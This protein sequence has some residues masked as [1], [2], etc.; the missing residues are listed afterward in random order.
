MCKI[1]NFCFKIVLIHLCEFSPLLAIFPP[2]AITNQE[3]YKISEAIF[4][5]HARYKHYSSEIVRRSLLNFIEELDPLRVYFIQEDIDE[6]LDPSPTFL[7]QVMNDYYHQK[8]SAFYDIYRCFLKAIHRRNEIEK[9]IFLEEI[10][11][12][13]SLAREPLDSNWARDSEGLKIKLLKFNE[14]QRVAAKNLPSD[15]QRDLLWQ[16]IQKRRLLKEKEF[17]DASFEDQKRQVLVYF[18]KAV[19][20]SLDSHTMF[21]T[22]QE[23]RQFFIQVQQKLFGIGAQLRDDLDGFTI[24][25][26]IPGG[27]AQRSGLLKI[28]DKL[29]AVD[30][31]P[32]AGM[33]ITEAV[34]W[35]RGP[36]G[37][38]IAL[39]VLRS[40][41]SYQKQIEVNITRD[42][43]ILTE[44]RYNFEGEPYGDGIIGYLALH[45]FYQDSSSSSYQDL[46]QAV[47]EL[48]ASSK[49]YGII[50]D[51]RHNAGGLLPQAID[52]S[53]LFIK[54]G[55]VASIKDHTGLIQRLRNIKGEVAWEGPL[56]VLI[57]RFTASAGEIVASAA[58]DYGRALIAGDCYSY[59]KG[60]YQALSIDS[61]NQGKINPIGEYKVTRGVY[62]SVGGESPQKQGVLSHIEVPGILNF[63]EIGEKFSK[64]PLEGGQIPPAYEDDLSD[65][66]PLQRG[67]WRKILGDDIQKRE[68]TI[69]PFIPDLAKHSQ[70]RIQNNENYQWFLSEVQRDKGGFDLTLSGQNDLQLEEA[71]NIMKE[72]ILFFKKERL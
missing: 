2:Q 10:V 47:Q 68:S 34:E 46:K 35:I 57:D 17:V 49:V 69:F 4:R 52:V 67:K 64:Y 28:G 19:S 29:V 43:I 44:S 27:P 18:L 26:M 51:L 71:Y 61:E 38:T 70:K 11:L 39:T 20:G 50:L 31:E 3:T 37:S 59:G 53:G 48:Q 7:K 24:V 21:F 45:S 56:L 40:E 33:D 5:S 32:I 23:A 36:R 63:L 72:L 15:V 41:G 66:H 62:Y 54:N 58:S 42:E 9:E 22:P 60:T 8:F 55:V 30:R 65:I 13:S 16:R 1:L 12:S 6:Y 25:H 14:L